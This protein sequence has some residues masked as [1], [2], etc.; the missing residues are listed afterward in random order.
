MLEIMNYP[1]EC[2][3]YAFTLRY[4]A[5]NLIKNEKL[6]KVTITDLSEYSIEGYVVVDKSKL[7]KKTN[8]FIYRI[9]INE[10][11]NDNILFKS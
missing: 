3:G 6:K 5:E 8:S 1:K 2:F 9:N 10:A 4:L 11:I 7:H